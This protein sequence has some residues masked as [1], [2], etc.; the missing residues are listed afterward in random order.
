DVHGVRWRVSRRRATVVGTM[1]RSRASQ[2]RSVVIPPADP[3]SA[4]AVGEA[5]RAYAR[6]ATIIRRYRAVDRVLAPISGVIPIAMALA[7]ALRFVNETAR[8]VAA[9]IGLAAAIIL[10]PLVLWKWWT[11]A[12]HRGRSPELDALFAEALARRAALR[13]RGPRIALS[14]LTT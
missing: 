5:S 14:A 8:S 1:V 11:I 3:S 6:D 2:K 13:R 12:T 10:L 7:A 9:L 4:P